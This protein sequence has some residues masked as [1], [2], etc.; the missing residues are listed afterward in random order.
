MNIKWNAS[1]QKALQA[2]APFVVILGPAGTGKTTLI[3]YCLKQCYKRGGRALI[4]TPSRKDAQALESSLKKVLPKKSSHVTVTDFLGYCLSRLDKKPFGFTD[5]RDRLFLLKECFQKLSISEKTFSLQA[6]G[7]RIQSYKRHLISPH[8]AK[9]KDRF[10]RVARRV[11]AEYQKKLQEVNLID[12][13]DIYFLAHEL[14]AERLSCDY[15]LADDYQELCYAQ[16]ALFLKIAKNAKVVRVFA[17]RLQNCFGYS[18]TSSTY[19]EE[20]EGRPTVQLTES[21]RLPKPILK[22]AQEL[23]HASSLNGALDAVETKV[24]GK[25]EVICVQDEHEE[26][27]HIAREVQSLHKKK[28]YADMAVFF[29][30]PAQGKCFEEAFSQLGIPFQTLLPSPFFERKEVKDVLSYL[31]VLHNPLDFLSLKRVLN[32]PSRGVGSSTLKRL[33]VKF[34]KRGL[35]YHDFF[36][37]EDDLEDFSHGVREKFQE[38]LG[39]L[40]EL[41]GQK[42]KNVVKLIGEVKEILGERKSEE[43]PKGALTAWDCFCS[44]AKAQKSVHDFIH[45]LYTLH[46]LDYY[47]RQRDQVLLAHITF[48]K[49]SVFDIVFI[50][51]MEEGIF[52]QRSSMLEQKEM[53]IERKLCYAAMSRAR[54]RVYFLYAT[55]RTL[56]GGSQRTDVSRFLRDMGLLN[57]VRKPNGVSK[58]EGNGKGNGTMRKGARVF[59]KMWGEGTVKGIRGNGEDAT[60]TI[61]FSTVGEKTLLKEFAPLEMI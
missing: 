25:A 44:E 54:E 48:N 5:E 38:V 49:V 39:V 6:V 55:N 16:H 28:A 11:Y 1:Q 19:L 46:P 42:E 33:E 10:E 36:A 17:D 40:K 37:S 50:A 26:A 14:K 2:K 7:L 35:P 4:L 53:E 47:Q 3:P 58:A 15:L 41:G 43:A 13:E 34:R 27:W 20:F 31:R 61:D 24:E 59:H 22:A 12:A 60:L 45:H 30:N 21:F 23:S 52:P 9:P 32:T 51:G 57:A 8:E 29:R 56:Y 18:G